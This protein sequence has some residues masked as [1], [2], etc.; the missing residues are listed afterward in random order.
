MG[1][2]NYIIIESREI[3]FYSKYLFLLYAGVSITIKNSFSAIPYL[4]TNSIRAQGRIQQGLV[5]VQRK[6]L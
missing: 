5:G 6:T 4:L 2:S 1:F 3:E